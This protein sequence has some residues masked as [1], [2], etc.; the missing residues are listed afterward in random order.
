MS[1]SFFFND[2]FQTKAVKGKNFHE[3]EEDALNN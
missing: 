3:I 1:V 2:Y